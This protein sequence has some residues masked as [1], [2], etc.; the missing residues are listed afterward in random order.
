M[1]RRLRARR[2]AWMA[3]TVV[4]LFLVLIACSGQSGEDPEV[5][6]ADQPGSS[7]STVN[8]TSEPPSDDPEERLLQFSRCLRDLGI[9]V[10]DAQDD[11][12]SYLGS[13]TPEERN[14]AMQNCQQY[15]PAGQHSSLSEEQKTQRLEYVKCL[16]EQGV[17]IQ[18]PDPVTG[19]FQ[20]DDQHRFLAP[21]AELAEAM[22]ACTDKAPQRLRQ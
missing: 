3:L 14:A 11:L 2:R 6:S 8:P 16:R 13:L 15:A 21:D 20:M 10:P 18:D 19:R 5:A 4:P 22:Q 9:D 1:K 12:M 7:G 17:D